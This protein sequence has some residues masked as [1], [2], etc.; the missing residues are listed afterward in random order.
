ML[1]EIADR[2]SSTCNSSS[3]TTIMTAEEFEKESSSSMVVPTLVTPIVSNVSSSSRRAAADRCH[4]QLSPPPL[5]RS[6]S[7]PSTM[8]VSPTRSSSWSSFECFLAEL[9]HHCGRT[10]PDGIFLP[11]LLDDE[12]KENSHDSY[13]TCN[14]APTFLLRPAKRM[15]FAC[16][17]L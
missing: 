11:L 8:L 3:S 13:S 2:Q 14:S 15:R 10:V 1:F 6:S 17:R 5:K 4:Q 9:E 12:N 16:W 7:P